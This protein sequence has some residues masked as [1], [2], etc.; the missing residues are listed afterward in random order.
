MW[1]E[2]WESSV[3]D[4]TFYLISSLYLLCTK[5]LFKTLGKVQMGYVLGEL[6]HNNDEIKILR[7]AE[8]IHNPGGL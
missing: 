7:F 4:L 6:I 8:Q 3:K 2:R 1:K 5:C